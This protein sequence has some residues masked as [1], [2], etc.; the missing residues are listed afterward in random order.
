M[1]RSAP[2]RG[3]P[4]SAQLGYRQPTPGCAERWAVE[5]GVRRVPARSADCTGAGSPVFASSRRRH[6]QCAQKRSS[7]AA[8]RF[9]PDRKPSLAAAMSR[10]WEVNCAANPRTGRLEHVQPYTG[11][12]SSPGGVAVAA[13]GKSGPPAQSSK[14]E[15]CSTWPAKLARWTTA[16]F[17][18]SQLADSRRPFPI[19]RRGHILRQMRVSQKALSPDPIHGKRSSRDSR[20][21]SPAPVGVK[22]SARQRRVR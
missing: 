13:G 19:R 9:P 4:C 8:W 1:R 22:S 14:V 16:D 7:V 18:R 2:F 11:P 3:F 5:R 12:L 10:R 17:T 21:R 20:L 6:Q 15:F